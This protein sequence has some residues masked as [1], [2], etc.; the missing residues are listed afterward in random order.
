[1]VQKIT[2]G[3]IGLGADVKPTTYVPAG[4]TFYETDTKIAWIFDGAN[5]NPVTGNGWWPL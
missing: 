4:F 5:I 1:M 2:N 3:Y